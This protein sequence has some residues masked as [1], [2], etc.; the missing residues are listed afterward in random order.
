[1]EAVVAYFSPLVEFLRRQGALVVLLFVLIHK[2]GDTLANLTLR[3]LF[4]DLGFSNDE[5]AFYD[6]G[7]GF[8]ALLAGVFAGGI[9]YARLGM[10]ASV[11]L[12]LVLMAISNLSFAALAAAG[13]TNAGMAAAVGFENFASGIGGVTVVAYLSALCNLRFTATQY[14]LLSALASIAGRFLTGTTAGGLIDAMGYVNFY[15]LTT[16]VAL[17]GVVLFWW[18]IRSGLADVAVG[19][20]GRES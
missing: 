1:M 5:V 6:V 14:A 8:G 2:I 15:L 7:I 9:L 4:Q 11:L 10:K 3:L 19:S 17:P 16:A 18:M 12:S 20:A 13:H